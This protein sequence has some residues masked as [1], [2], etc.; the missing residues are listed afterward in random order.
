MS[1]EHWFA[2]AAASAVLLALPGPTIRLVISYALGHGRN[3]AGATVAGVALGDF[4]AMTASMLGLLHVS[5]N[6]L[7][8]T[9]K[10]MQPFKVLQRPLRVQ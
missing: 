9:D 3:T 4:T 5:L 10:N 6:R 8:F 1:F 7:R 2:F